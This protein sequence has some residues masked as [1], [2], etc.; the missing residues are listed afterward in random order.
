VAF[1]SVQQVAL[2]TKAVLDELQ[3]RSYVKTSGATG[4]HIVVPLLANRFTHEQVRLVAAAIAKMVVDR[5]PHI[6]TVGR[7]VND[8]IGKVYVDFGQN[9]RG[10]TIASVYSPRARPKA[11]VSTP[12]KWEELGRPADPMAFTMRTVFKRLERVGDPWSTMWKQ[13]QDIGPFCEVLRR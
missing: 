5:R 9:G 7:R 1:A 10:R 11:P 13:R 4:L 2:V 12:L 8:R 6:A 3:L